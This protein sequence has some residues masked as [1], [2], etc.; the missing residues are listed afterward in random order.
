M[1]NVTTYTTAQ[2]L[3][4]YNAGNAVQTRKMTS[5]YREIIEEVKFYIASG[6][7]KNRA[8]DFCIFEEFA[9]MFNGNTEDQDNLKSWMI[10][11]L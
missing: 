8:I 9:F 1:K 2:I 10:S 7:D 4:I 3:A 6:W 11:N 5:A